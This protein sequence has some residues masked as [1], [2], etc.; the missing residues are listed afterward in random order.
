ML[1]FGSYKELSQKK[2]CLMLK[3]DNDSLN[4]LENDVVAE[5]RSIAGVL[6]ANGYSD[7]SQAVRAVTEYSHGVVLGL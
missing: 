6:S 4:D 3:K 2:E 5:C 1:R 7:H